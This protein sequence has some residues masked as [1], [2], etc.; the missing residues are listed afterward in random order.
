M[1]FGTPEV[2][3]I[4][5]IVILWL[6]GRSLR[7]RLGTRTLTFERTADIFIGLGIVA[8]FL[9]TFLFLSRR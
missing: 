6:N 4:S 5:A 9:A 3:I 8:A 7:G 1:H 2:M